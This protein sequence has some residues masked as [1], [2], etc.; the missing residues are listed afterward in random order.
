MDLSKSKT[1]ATTASNKTK[2]TRGN[3]QEFLSSSRQASVNASSVVDHALVERIREQNRSLESNLPF[4][5]LRMKNVQ[6][7][8]TNHFED[9]PNKQQHNYESA[10]QQQAPEG[11]RRAT[12]HIETVASAGP[13]FRLWKKMKRLMT[14]GKCT[15]FEQDTIIVDNINLVF[16]PGKMVLLLGGPGSGAYFFITDLTVSCVL[17]WQS[18]LVGSFPLFRR[19][20]I[21]GRSLVDTLLIY[22]TW[23]CSRNVMIHRF[24]LFRKKYHPPVH[25]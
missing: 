17:L 22:P 16:E 3:H 10:N 19:Y 21:L 20:N 7:T 18:K 11:P 24:L 23:S 14:K 4:M 6:Y 2:G 5:E 15:D 8:I 13:M 25:Q 12:Q 1:A 9:D